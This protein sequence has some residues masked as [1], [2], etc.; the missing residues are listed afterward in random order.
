[1]EEIEFLRGFAHELEALF[2]HALEGVGR[3]A[4]LEG[5]GAQDFGSGFG[6]GF[7]HRED[8]LAGFDGTRAGGD[9]YFVAADFYAAAEVDDGAFGLELAAGQL[10]G[11]GDAHDFAHSVEELEIAKIEIAMDTDRAEDGVRF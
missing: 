2:A 8:L 4:R 6:D 7:G 9:H 10:E 1:G 3:G 11:L 5:A